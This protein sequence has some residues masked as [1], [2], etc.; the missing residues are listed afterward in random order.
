LD[1]SLPEF[2]GFDIL[3]SIRAQSSVPILIVSAR[4]DDASRI[5][6]LEVGADDYLS[7]PFNPRELIARIRALLRRGY[8][9]APTTLS[10]SEQL[11][12]GDLELDK[13]AWVVRRAGEQVDLTTTE[14]QLLEA[15]LRS[16]G[17]VLTRQEL[18]E[19]VFGRHFNPLDRSV[20]MHVSNL[21]R[22]LSNG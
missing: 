8:S 13:G 20:D 22:K 17:R 1:V 2:N 21:R 5:L 10:A 19:N 7:K 9:P 4:S 14:L 3:C 12:I 18:V 15:L 6:G 11:S 16:A